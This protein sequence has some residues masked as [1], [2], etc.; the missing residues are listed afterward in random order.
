VLDFG[1]ELGGE[2][3]DF[4]VSAVQ[5]AQSPDL[6]CGG[7]VVSGGFGFLATVGGLECCD[8]GGLRVDNL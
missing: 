5:Q 1:D 6:V 4:L 2:N 8:F 7:R 3:V